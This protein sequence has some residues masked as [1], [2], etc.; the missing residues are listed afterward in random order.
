MI[1]EHSNEILVYTYDGSGRLPEFELVQKVPTYLDNDESAKAASAL[2]I[3]PSGDY[4]YCS[5]AGEETVGIFKI[6]HETGKLTKIC[7]LPIS[8]KYPKGCGSPSRMKRRWW[9]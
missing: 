8:G 2:K 6:D 3:S 4:L 1:C 7:I 5:T 9:S